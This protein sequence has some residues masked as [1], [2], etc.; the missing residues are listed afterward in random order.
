MY[1]PLLRAYPTLHYQ[2]QTYFSDYNPRTDVLL[3]LQLTTYRRSPHVVGRLTTGRVPTYRRTPSP[4]TFFTFPTTHT[5]RGP[6]PIIHFAHVPDYAHP[7]G[8]IVN[9]SGTGSYHTVLT[10]S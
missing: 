6:V 8:V 4:H 2:L 9:V 7:Y 10:R 1:V 5:R 3:S